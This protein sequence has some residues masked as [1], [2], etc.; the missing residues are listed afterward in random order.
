MH[1]SL[2]ALVFCIRCLCTGLGYQMIFYIP[3]NLFLSFSTSRQ[4]T[5]ANIIHRAYNIIHQ[6][7]STPYNNKLHWKKDSSNS[8]QHSNNSAAKTDQTKT[9]I[10]KL[11]VGMILI[12]CF[13]YFLQ[14][15]FSEN[16]SYSY[17]LPSESEL[18]FT[19][20]HTHSRAYSHMFYT[21]FRVSI[22]LKC[23]ENGG[24]YQSIA[25]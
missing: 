14:L 22:W 11:L 24:R 19:H 16:I 20:T 23:A 1:V 5:L 4:M 10:I 18:P 25:L 15:L 2:F 8:Q 12:C 6:K 3:I 9:T 21:W 17:C 13:V 7:P